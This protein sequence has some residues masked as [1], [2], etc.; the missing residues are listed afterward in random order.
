MTCP[1]IYHLGKQQGQCI[2]VPNTH[3]MFFQGQCQPSDS[4]FWRNIPRELKLESALVLYSTIPWS[5]QKVKF[6]ILE[7]SISILS[8]ASFSF[9]PFN[10]LF[11]KCLLCARFV[12][13]TMRI[14]ANKMEL[15]KNH[16]EQCGSPSNQ[17][18]PEVASQLSRS[19]VSNYKAKL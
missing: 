1:H 7:N 6:R 8:L 18:V 17:P 10:H 13:G 2:S 3:L 5:H 9:I 11:N 19:L 15:S 16:L 12:L 14:T 4:A